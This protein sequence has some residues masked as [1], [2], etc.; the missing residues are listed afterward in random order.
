MRL[1]KLVAALGLSALAFPTTANAQEFRSGDIFAPFVLICL[2]NVGDSEAQLDAAR[3][4]ESV[5]E[6]QS[7]WTLLEETTSGSRTLLTFESAFVEVSSSLCSFGSEVSADVTREVF[8]EGLTEIFGGMEPTPR[9]G[10][11]EVSWMAGIGGNPVM[12]SADLI[13]REQSNYAL[14]KVQ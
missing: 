3:S 6:P 8:V 7:V 13:Q 9:I 11:D 12:I 2:Q 10:S 14:L 5:T 4:L 1:G